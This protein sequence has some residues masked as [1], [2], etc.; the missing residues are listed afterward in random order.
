MI[1][2]AIIIVIVGAAVAAGLVWRKFYL[3]V[4]EK[5]VAAARSL[6]ADGEEKQ[7][8]TL[9]NRLAFAG[10][11]SPERD[12]ARLLLARI[13]TD[14]QD[15]EPAARIWEELAADPAS[16]FHEEALF[17]LGLVAKL[18]GEVDRSERYWEEHRRRYPDS[19]RRGGALSAR[20]RRELEEGDLE[21][22][23]E[24]YLEILERFPSGT[25]GEEAREALGEINLEL[26]YSP[27][28]SPGF[29]RYTVR[30]GDTLTSIAARHGTTAELLAGINGID[31]H[32]IHIGQTLKVP[33]ERFE[34]VVSKS[35]NNLTLYYGGEFFKRY[36]VGT[37]LGG[38]TPEGE[39]RVVTK[40]IDPP[41]YHRGRVIPP[42]DPDNILGT[43][44]LGFQDPYAAYGIHGTVEPET[45]GTQSSA[46][47]VRM[48]NRDV[49][50]LFDFLPRQTRVII[51]E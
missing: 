48:L 2:R 24:T 18:G 25:V 3:P 46:G 43:R 17:Q 22:A 28:I 44:W 9:L 10:R 49:E 7:A 45:I 32:L 34:V 38:S 6:L 16:G 5:D 33:R 27:V 29:G 50:E 1:K 42:H 15:L 23:R 14:R 41:W 11:P 12:E 35:E 13:Y 21:A 47:C 36:P 37:G 39:F 20:A 4:G 30:S 26:L 19:P 40:L 8:L 51:R 31:G